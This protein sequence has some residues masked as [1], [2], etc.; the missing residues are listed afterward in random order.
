MLTPAIGERKF[1][2]AL[3]CQRLA[4]FRCALDGFER[5]SLP[6]TQLNISKE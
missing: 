3:R 6:P 1:F 5:A 2:E 4:I